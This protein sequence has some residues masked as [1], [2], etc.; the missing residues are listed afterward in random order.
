MK[1]TLIV[2]ALNEIEGMKAIMP[3][4]D[5]SWCDQVIVVDG[6]SADGTVEW[7]R[8]QGW[9]VHQ[10][11]RPGIRQGYIEA[12][13][14]VEGDVVITFSP[15]GNSIPE[16]IPELIAKM[17]EGYDMVIAS[18]YLDDA[19]SDDD[20]I[21]TGFGN[22]F[23][24]RTANLLFGAKY[25]DAMVIYRAFKKGMIQE[26][27]LDQDVAHR[28]VERL[29][30]TGY[31]IFSWEPLLSVRAI[32]YNY[33]VGEIPASEPKRI[34]GE[35]KLRVFRWGASFYCQFLRE[36]LTGADPARIPRDPKPEEPQP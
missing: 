4:I 7:A 31:R 21:V 14:S 16:K 17:G 12:W 30:L 19:S 18:R 32:K 8:E 11:K 25:T 28:W 6:G 15:D 5:P 10:Q 1:T 27:G 26:L 29:F 3:R 9:T 33:R 34:G 22:W 24:T 23:F 13:P 20:D 35:R 2:M 36:F